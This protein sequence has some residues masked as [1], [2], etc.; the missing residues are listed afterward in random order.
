MSSHALLV[1]N[2]GQLVTLAEHDGPVGVAPTELASI[3]DAALLAVDGVIVALGPAQDVLRSTSDDLDPAVLDAEGRC[4]TPGLVDCHSHLLYEGERTDEY[5]L[6]LNGAS[7]Q[8]IAATGGGLYRSVAG[9]RDAGSSRLLRS[10]LERLDTALASGTTTVEIKTGYGLSTAT[11]LEQLRV[12]HAADRLHP[13]D[14]V[15]TWFGAHG[16]PP[17]SR[18][19]PDAYVAQLIDEQIPAAATIARFCDVLCD[20]GVFEPPAAARILDAAAR[21]GLRLRL[22]ADETAGVGGAELAADRNVVAAAHLNHASKAGLAAMA[23]AGC[24]AI[25]LPATRFFHLTDRDPDVAWMRRLGLPMALGTD[26]RPTS[27]VGSMLTVMALACGEYG[28]SPEQ[29]LV[30]ATVNAAWAAGREKEA[31]RLVPGRPADLA[32]FDVADYREL[33]AYLDRPITRFV[34]KNGVPVARDHAR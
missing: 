14:V 24:I 17:E 8:D 11:E 13:I 2:I 22:L 23:H 31:G 5:W 10:L 1:V 19:D 29:A 4:V 32:C 15:E 21:A 26:H 30:G 25:V 7:N 18:D 28:F 9:A 27:P 33:P 34:V 6:R 12:L 20:R 3:A 16:Y